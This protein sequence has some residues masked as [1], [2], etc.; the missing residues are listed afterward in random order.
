M[1]CS[2]VLSNLMSRGAAATKAG[3][4]MGES[5]MSPRPLHPCSGAA[6]SFVVGGAHPARDVFSFDRVAGCEAEGV[7]G[8]RS[9]L[10][11]TWA[12]LAGPLS[13]R[14][15]AIN[16]AGAGVRTDGARDA[17]RS[18]GGRVAAGAL[19][20]S[21]VSVSVALDAERHQRAQSGTG[22]TQQASSSRVP[23]HRL[24]CEVN[25]SAS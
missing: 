7:H 18:G 1:L 6:G 20:A 4:L 8:L 15:L 25:G 17:D 24:G 13:G 21:G 10:T 11:S 9:E 16:S 2:T 23:R 12:S 19:R 3:V 5:C 22:P 14:R